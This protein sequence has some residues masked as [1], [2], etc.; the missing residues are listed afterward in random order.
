MG[1]EQDGV[2]APVQLPEEPDD[3]LAG[4]AVE[5]AG[6]LVG[7]EQ[8]RVAHQRPGDG[9]A[10]ALAARELVGAVVHAVLEPHRLER[11]HG[12]VA[13]LL[14]G[15]AA[16]DER[17][18]HVG[19]GG[20]P[21]E[22]LEGLEDEADLVVAQ[23]GELVVGELLHV[24]PVD[25]V[26]AG[27]GGVER[28]DEVHEGRLARA[29]LPHHRHPLAA[30]HVEGDAVEGAHL[31]LADPVEPGEP[32][33]GDERRLGHVPAAFRASPETLGA[34]LPASFGGASAFTARPS[35]R[36]RERIL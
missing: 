25:P 22:Q 28:A 29:R 17:E 33:D 24:L 2:A 27:G 8:R 18:L 1:H 6:G 11:L 30:P 20:G 3:L 14:A 32:L 12:A 13:T 15:D 36:S 31:L 19:E 23:V 10:L 21:G 16:V 35:A 26:G 4:C 7:E 5:V 34:S 9:H